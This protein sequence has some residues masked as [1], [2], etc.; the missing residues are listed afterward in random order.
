MRLRL[1]LSASLIRVGSIDGESGRLRLCVLDLNH[2]QAASTSCTHDEDH[3]FE[4]QMKCGCFGSSAL[5]RGALVQANVSPVIVDSS[6][7]IA[8][9][10]SKCDVRLFAGQSGW[11]RARYLGPF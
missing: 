6:D 7:T 10:S 3:R 5:R 4:V 9:A 8:N 1:A 11:K 2:S